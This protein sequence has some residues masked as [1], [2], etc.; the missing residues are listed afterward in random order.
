MLPPWDHVH[1]S[2]IFV[3]TSSSFIFLLNSPELRIS[4]QTD[5]SVLWERIT[6][7]GPPTLNVKST[8]SQAG[9]CAEYRGESRQAWWHRYLA[10]EKGKERSR[11]SLGYIW[12]SLK[13]KRNTTRSEWWGPRLHWVSAVSPFVCL[14]S[15]RQVLKLGWYPRSPSNAPASTPN[16]DM[17]SGILTQTL[18][19]ARQALSPTEPQWIVFP[20]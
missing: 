6:G 8:F 7:Q 5:L 13:M 17:C 19:L 1:W 9:V 14:I 11:D 20:K 18:L 2:G 15:L 3:S 4:L 12:P 16:F 10:S